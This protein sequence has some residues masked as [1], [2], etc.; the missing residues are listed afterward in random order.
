MSFE[1][2]AVAG[3]AGL[4]AAAA[5]SAS[6]AVLVQ[7]STPTVELASPD[8]TGAT[9]ASGA[10]AA[11]LD[12]TLRGY[13]TLDGDHFWIDVFT[14]TLDGNTLLQGT[15]DLGGGGTDRVLANPVGATATKSA[16]GRTV[17]V[18][19][20]LALTAGTHLLTLAYDSPAT[21]EGVP[22]AGFQGLGDEGWGIDALT[23]NGVSAPAGTVPEPAS[24]ALALAGLGTL[25][26]ARRRRHR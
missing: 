21:F 7:W 22:R 25:A 24:V 13:Q 6:A 14:L 26:A 19:A 16:D 11:T 20:A 3:L 4:V 15:W 10:G 12:F 18:S 1:R 2:M 23:V 5:G 17:S 8:S 9:F